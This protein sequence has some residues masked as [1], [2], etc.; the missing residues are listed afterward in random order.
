MRTSPSHP[1]HGVDAQDVE[2]F[3]HDGRRGVAQQ[4]TPHVH[5]HNLTCRGRGRGGELIDYYFLF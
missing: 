3:G 5:L 1:L 2:A 4:H